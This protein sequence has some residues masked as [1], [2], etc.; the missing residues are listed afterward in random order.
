MNGNG[1]TKISEDN[2][3][4]VQGS[5]KTWLLDFYTQGCSS[6]R[7]VEPH[8]KEIAENGNGVEI[9]KIDVEDESQLLNR[10]GVQH[11]PTIVIYK[12]GEEKDRI[13]GARTGSE[14]RKKIEID[15]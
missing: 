7:K 6:C 3:E 11:L 13:I 5:D 14:I 4:K 1:I 9:G 10:F 12:E 8:L 2:F 15:S